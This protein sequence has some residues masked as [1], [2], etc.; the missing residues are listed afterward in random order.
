[1]GGSKVTSGYPCRVACLLCDPV[2]V[3][4]FLDQLAEHYV[5][6]HPISVLVPRRRSLRVVGE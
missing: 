4:D 5:R 1:M 6:E 2:P 3:F